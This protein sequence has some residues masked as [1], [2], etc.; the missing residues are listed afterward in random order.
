MNV[1][2]APGRPRSEEARQAVLDAVDDLLVEVGYA[3]MTMKNIAERAGVGRPTVYRWWSG[4]AEILV[5]ACTQDA[6]DELVVAPHPDP[7]HELASYLELL[8]RFLTEEPPGLACRALIGEAQHDPQVADL[9]HRADLLTAPTVV[10]LDRVRVHAPGMPE[11][12]LAVAQVM[13]PVLT[14]VLTTGQAMPGRLVREHTRILLAAW[15]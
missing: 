1:S 10:V 5:E 13:G 11:N 8:G 9:V 7:H 4:K 15:R 6:T 12:A 14:H 3:A 2:A